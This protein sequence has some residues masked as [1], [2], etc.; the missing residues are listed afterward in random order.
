V[1]KSYRN[2]LQILPLN[3][4]RTGLETAITVRNAGDEFGEGPAGKGWM[5]DHPI[6]EVIRLAD[7]QW[8]AILTYRV[9]ARRDAPDASYTGLYVEEVSSSGTPRSK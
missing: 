3:S 7:G 6:S 9:L 5:V 1:P 4:A 2:A 8:H